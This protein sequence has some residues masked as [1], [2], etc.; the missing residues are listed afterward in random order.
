MDHTDCP[1]K[2]WLDTLRYLADVHKLLA[3]ESL[4]W[5]NQFTKL[6]GF[7]KDISAYLHYPYQQPVCYLD[8]DAK[9]PSSKEQPGYWVGMADNV[10][11]MLTYKIHDAVTNCL[12]CKSIVRPADDDP[13]MP[14]H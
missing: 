4:G 1:D 2:G 9:F 13:L 3:K 6:Q 12:V 5:I 7:T 14:N 8:V 11:D 10:G